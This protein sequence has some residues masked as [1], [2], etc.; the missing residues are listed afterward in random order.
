VDSQEKEKV[1]AHRAAREM[2]AA[3]LTITLSL[4]LVLV[5]VALVV[6]IGHI[7]LF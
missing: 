7:R 3:A 5:L 6:V 4:V 2:K 1:D